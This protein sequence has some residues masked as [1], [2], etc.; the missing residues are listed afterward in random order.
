LLLEGESNGLSAEIPNTETPM[1]GETSSAEEEVPLRGS[2]APSLDT[3]EGEDP[4]PEV[5]AGSAGTREPEDAMVV[6][7]PPGASPAT[8]ELIFSGWLPVD[9]GTIPLE[10]LRTIVS[11]LSSAEQHLDLDFSAMAFWVPK[12]H[13]RERIEFCERIRD[14]SAAARAIM[15]SVRDSC[16][17]ISADVCDRIE[18]TRI[19][20]N[21]VEAR[22]ALLYALGHHGKSS[23][24]VR[25]A[26]HEYVEVLERDFLGPVMREAAAAPGPARSGLFAQWAEELRLV[27]VLAPSLQG[28]LMRV[29]YARGEEKDG[30]TV[31][32][33]M[34]LFTQLLDRTF[35]HGRNLCE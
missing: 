15:S 31:I 33:R 21:I 3:G 7:E 29:F 9:R 13:E 18:P 22:R 16:Y 1:M 32:A 35:R 20:A 27:L 2:A 25:Q 8:V 4:L 23:D 24:E 12:V 30:G 17:A 19:P 6:E 10:E 5:E 34:R 28:D 14:T 26:L 11:V